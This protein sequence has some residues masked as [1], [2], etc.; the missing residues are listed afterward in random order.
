M[1]SAVQDILDA[2]ICLSQNLRGSIR[3]MDQVAAAI[4][5]VTFW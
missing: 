4:Y 1:G 2:E 5:A 3:L